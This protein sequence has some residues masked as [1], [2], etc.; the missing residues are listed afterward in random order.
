MSAPGWDLLTFQSPSI[1]QT[2]EVAPFLCSETTEL[3]QQIQIYTYHWSVDEVLRLTAFL[4]SID[5]IEVD[6]GGMANGLVSIRRDFNKQ[7]ILNRDCNKKENHIS[8]NLLCRDMVCSNFLPL[9][10]QIKIRMIKNKILWISC[11]MCEHEVVKKLKRCHMVCV[12]ISVMSMCDFVKIHY[13]TGL[14]KK[15]HAHVS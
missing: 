8:E 10:F 11:S 7:H 13:N 15:M 4:L 9:M 3:A 12:L 14:M 5:D 6:F 1:S 2:F